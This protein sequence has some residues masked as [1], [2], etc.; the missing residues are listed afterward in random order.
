MKIYVFLFFILCNGSR[1]IK[2]CKILFECGEYLGMLQ[3]VS[4]SY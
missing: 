3:F 4:S 2:K 1:G